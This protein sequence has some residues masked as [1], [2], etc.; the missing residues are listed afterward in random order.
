MFLLSILLTAFIY[1]S[2]SN[3]DNVARFLP[4][5]K[6]H[7]P[8]VYTLLGEIVAHKRFDI[9]H[10]I[11]VLGG[12]N[13]EDTW[14]LLFLVPFTEDGYLYN[15]QPLSEPYVSAIEK[16]Q[17][18]KARF[19]M[20]SGSLFDVEATL[21]EVEES[22]RWIACESKAYAETEEFAQSELRSLRGRYSWFAIAYARKGSW[23]VAHYLL[24]TAPMRPHEVNLDELS[25][26][27]SLDNRFHIVNELLRLGRKPESIFGGFA[28]HCQLFLTKES[29]L[30]AGDLKI[31]AKFVALPA[32]HGLPFLRWATSNTRP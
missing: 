27:L 18:L 28:A 29:S 32:R 25:W 9:L 10:L 4:E 1:C 17:E 3:E 13:T 8:L 5:S 2:V 26:C 7:L 20:L 22:L 15:E 16:A 23:D 19:E 12:W 14:T 6:P 11:R 30:D 21:L 24:R 31:K